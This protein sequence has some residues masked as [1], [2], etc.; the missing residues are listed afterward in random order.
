M[1]FDREK[2]IKNISDTLAWLTTA[3]NYRG[4]QNLLDSHVIAEDFFAG[5][6]NIVYEYELMNLN[7]RHPNSPF[8]DLHDIKNGVAFQVTAEKKRSKIQNTIKGFVENGLYATYPNLYIFILSE[9][10]S[11]RSEFT[12]GNKIKFD[13]ETNI[14]DFKRLLLAI[15]SLS[16]EQLIEIDAYFSREISLPIESSEQEIDHIN[17]K[18]LELLKNIENFR[19]SDPKAVVKA[20]GVPYRTAITQLRKSWVDWEFSISKWLTSDEKIK[21]EDIG[22]NSLGMNNLKKGENVMEIRKNV[23]AYTYLVVDRISKEQ[24]QMTS[25]RS[26]NQNEVSPEYIYKLNLLKSEYDYKT[27]EA[28]RNR[29]ARAL[30]QAEREFKHKSGLLWLQHFGFT[31]RKK[32]ID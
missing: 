20:A 8:I 9:S 2:R 23:R 26:S 25:Y 16:T 31:Q 19:S 1:I 27:E 22:D 17:T 11:P 13:K 5:L 28:L 7:Y 14:I 18:A 12:T 29:N 24:P 4:I 30:L 32:K 21:V 10:Y 6:L 15:R 3:I